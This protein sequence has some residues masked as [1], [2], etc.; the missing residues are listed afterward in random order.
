MLIKMSFHFSRVVVVSGIALF[1]WASLT[2]KGYR[3]Q[4]GERVFKE[5]VHQL[6]K[7]PEVNFFSFHDCL[8]N[9]N[10]SMLERFC[11]LVIDH[12]KNGYMKPI[13]WWCQ[14]VIRPEM[15]TVLLEKMKEGRLS[16]DKLWY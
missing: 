6:Q 10:I 12:R 11:E 8:I 4:S 1:A 2:G 14:A 13:Q 7:Y 16:K 3:S 5:V 9:G 15:T